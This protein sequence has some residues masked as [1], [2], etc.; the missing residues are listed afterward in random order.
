MGKGAWKTH[1]KILVTTFAIVVIYLLSWTPLLYS[2]VCMTDPSKST[3]LE[4]PDRIYKIVIYFFMISLIANPAIYTC[5][6]KH[7]K[8]FLAVEIRSSLG[9]ISNVLFSYGS[10]RSQ[11]S[12]RSGQMADKGG[13]VVLEDDNDSMVASAR[14]SADDTLDRA[15][16]ENGLTT[17]DLTKMTAFSLT[18]VMKLRDTALYMES[19][20]SDNGSVLKPNINGLES[21][22]NGLDSDDEDQETDKEGQETKVLPIRDNNGA[23]PKV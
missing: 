6:N 9:S 10:K 18:P 15:G 23:E 2:W 1:S 11:R 17:W 7:F 16:R 8:T 12:I 5:I 20:N 3:L 13:D 21:N 4:I 22:I 14:Y 19:L